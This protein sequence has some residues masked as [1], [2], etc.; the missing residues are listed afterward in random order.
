[1]Q[2]NK[3]TIREKTIK[4]SVEHF[5]KKVQNNI[6]EVS[7]RKKITITTQKH[8]TKEKTHRRTKVTKNVVLIQTWVGIV[9]INGEK[10]VCVW[11][12][13]TK[14]HTVTGTVWC[15]LYYTFCRKCAQM[16]SCNCNFFTICNNST[17]LLADSDLTYFLL[18]ISPCYL[19]FSI[20][21]NF[22]SSHLLQCWS[23]SQKRRE[24][25]SGN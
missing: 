24:V 14:L 1:M 17:T 9:C 16:L 20:N 15:C 22:W 19:N 25:K 5:L 3:N 11:R 4:K 13:A 2:P 7:R 6:L 10:R 12:N 8:S 18:L 23:L 21:S